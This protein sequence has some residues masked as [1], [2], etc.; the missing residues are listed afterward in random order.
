M[1]GSR[2]IS[3]AIGTAA[4]IRRSAASMPATTL[5]AESSWRIAIF[6]ATSSVSGPEVQRAKVNNALHLGTRFNS[7]H[8]RGLDVHSG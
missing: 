3:F 2:K 5:A 8:D 6:A 1:S 7:S 4:R